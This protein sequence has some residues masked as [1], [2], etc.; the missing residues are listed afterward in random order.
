M[1]P[2]LADPFFCMSLL[3]PNLPRSTDALITQPMVMRVPRLE[4]SRF[5]Q[6]SSSIEP[7]CRHS[8]LLSSGGRRFGVQT[9]LIMIVTYF[10]SLPGCLFN[11]F[12]KGLLLC[13][14]MQHLQSDIEG[15]HSLLGG[16]STLACF[17]SHAPKIFRVRVQTKPR[18]FAKLGYL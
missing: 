13:R 14:C 6:S 10:S 7:R 1:Q 8:P 2:P 5:D 3:Y 16:V 4:E 17:F 11:H 18:P 9:A 12:W 15:Y